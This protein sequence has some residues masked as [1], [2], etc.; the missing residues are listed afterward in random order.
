MKY[1]VT[2]NKGLELELPLH[3]GLRKGKGFLHGIVPWPHGSP[4]SPKL[5]RNK[6]LALQLLMQVYDA[7]HGPS[8]Y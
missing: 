6:N 1:P 7:T 8:S 5:D 4:V 2:I 3:H